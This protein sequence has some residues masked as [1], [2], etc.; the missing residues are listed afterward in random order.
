MVMATL[1]LTFR[2]L[3]RIQNPDIIIIISAMVLVGSLATMILLLYDR[4]QE[5]ENNLNNKIDANERSIM[6]GIN[7]IEDNLEK[8]MN[9][10]MEK[11]NN[12]VDKLSKK[13]FR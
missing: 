3:T 6:I 4:L 1:V 2:W 8:K 10:F 12:A 5:I 11:T 7:G 13:I 9:S